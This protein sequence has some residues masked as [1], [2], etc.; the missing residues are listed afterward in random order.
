M[1][2]PNEPKPRL[3]EVVELYPGAGRVVGVVAP[4]R[5]ARGD[6]PWPPP[7]PDSDMPPSA[8]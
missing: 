2:T 1:T 3:A 6:I 5:P 7:P 8:A 4:M